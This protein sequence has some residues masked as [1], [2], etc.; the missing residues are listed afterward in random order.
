MTHEERLQ[1]FGTWP[2]PPFTDKASY[3]AWVATWKERYKRL[4]AYIRQHRCQHRI[5]CSIEDQAANAAGLSWAAR[6]ENLMTD[7][8]RKAVEQFK[9]QFTEEL[10][11]CERAI[12]EADPVNIDG[13]RTWCSADAKWWTAEKVATGMLHDRHRAKATS[14]EMAK[15]LRA[16]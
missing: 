10:S 12:L 16:V 4:S 9:K 2:S 6:F 14:W 13:F 7:A 1:A 3:L 8:Q 5:Q 15:H 11:P